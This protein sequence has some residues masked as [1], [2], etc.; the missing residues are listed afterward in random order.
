M[1]TPYKQ[2]Y[3]KRANYIA[4]T[5]QTLYTRSMPP[6]TR[7]EK[8][9][10]ETTPEILPTEAEVNTGSPLGRL[11]GFAAI[12][13]ESTAPQDPRDCTMIMPRLQM[14]MIRR[15]MKGRRQRQK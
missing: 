11:F 2:F 9:L 3:R 8:G 7:C 14:S 1:K 5:R 4:P 6:Y 12:L 13:R 15:A 10:A